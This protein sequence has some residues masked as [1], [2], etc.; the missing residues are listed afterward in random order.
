MQL[1]HTVALV[2]HIAAGA[3]GLLLAAP[4]LL[5]P[6]RRGRH[7]RLGRAYAVA[8]AVLCASAFVLAVYD[9]AA[10]WPFII[11]GCA[12]AASAGSGVWMARRR[13][14]RDW[15]IW[16]FNLMGSSVIAFVTAFA[17]QMTGNALWAIITPTLIGAPLIA[18]RTAVT[19]TARR[20]SPATRT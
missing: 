3:T 19:T 2:A 9:P 12:T 4:I 18:Y 17:M 8:T 20:P 10:L 16:H 13:P 5:A 14:V 1:L 11:I 7:T 6:K 15:Y